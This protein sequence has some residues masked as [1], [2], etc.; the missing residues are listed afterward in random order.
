MA[1]IIVNFVLFFLFFFIEFLAGVNFVK[2]KET[3]GGDLVLFIFLSSSVIN[4]LLIITLQD[5]ATKYD[6]EK[7]EKN[8]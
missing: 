2:L 1:K 8:K 3:V 7:K 6:K 4:L 5:A